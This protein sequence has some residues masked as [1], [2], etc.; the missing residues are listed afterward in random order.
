MFEFRGYFGL[1][2]SLAHQLEHHKRPR[3][4]ELPAPP[5]PESTQQPG[6]ALVT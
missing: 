2:T 5:K 3:F 6:A 4:Q 1:R